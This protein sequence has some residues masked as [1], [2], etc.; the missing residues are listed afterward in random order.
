MADFEVFVDDDRYSVP[1][2]YL[3]SANG[4]A[5][6][7]AIIDEIWR[8]SQHHQGVELRRDGE[9]LWG[10][11]SLADGPPAGRRASAPEASGSAA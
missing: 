10:L 6:A 2:L 1:S 11:G 3:I 8:S 9:R 5:R 4:E 7:R